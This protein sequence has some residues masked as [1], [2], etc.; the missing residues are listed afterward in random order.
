MAKAL[1]FA[2]S[3]RAGLVLA[4]SNGLV[5]IVAVWFIVS[6]IRIHC[7]EQNIDLPEVITCNLILTIYRDYF[8]PEMKNIYCT[9]VLGSRLL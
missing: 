1:S 4:L 3:N 9:D 5:R 6:P 2:A 7:L 8:S